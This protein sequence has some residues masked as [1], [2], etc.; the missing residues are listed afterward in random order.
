MS[1][2]TVFLPSLRLGSLFLIKARGRGGAA[3]LGT[4]STRLESVSPLH[5]LFTPTVMTLR[6]RHLTLA[7]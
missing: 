3:A 6:S 7:S 4:H 1:K 2:S 5:E